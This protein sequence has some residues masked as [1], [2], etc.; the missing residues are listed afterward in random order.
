[1]Y[2]RE[3][4]K[5]IEMLGGGK[6]NT[7]VYSVEHLPTG[8]IYALK[9]VEAKDLDKLNEYKEEAFQLSKVQHHP[10]ILKCHG[11]YFYQTKHKSYKLGIISEYIS[12]E[13]NL[14]NLFRKKEKS[15]Q[16]WSEEELLKIAYS[17]IDTLAYLESCGICHRDIKPQ[18][19][20][21]LSNFEIKIIDFGESIEHFEED[22][23][24]DEKA[25]IRGTP[26]Y[27]SPILW[28]GHVI[29]KEREI[30]HNMFKSDVFSTGLVLFQLASFKDISGFNM[31][32]DKV[33]GEKLIKEGIKYI[34][35]KYSN[36]L[37]D[38]I[39]KML[40]FNENERPTFIEMGKFI[41]SDEYVPKAEKNIFTQ[42]EELQ[43]KK[44]SILENTD[45][46]TNIS[47]SKE[48]SNEERTKKFIEYIQNNKVDINLNKNTYWFEYGGNLCEKMNFNDTNPQSKLTWKFLFKNKFDF[49]YH[50]NIV[51]VNEKY[52]YFLIGGRD[53]LNNFQFKDGE[54]IQKAPMN[55]KRS[56]TITAV[57]N[58]YIF[59]IGGF[60]FIQK[61]QMSSIEVYEIEKDSWRKNYIKN[62]NVPRSSGNALVYNGDAILVFGGFNK[63][64]GTLNSIEKIN[65]KTKDCE[66]LNI[67]MPV[68]LRRFSLLKISDSKILILGG[69]EKH[70]KNNEDGFILNIQSGKYDIIKDICKGGILEHEIIFD[71]L[72]YM[73]LFFEN[74]FGTSPPEHQQIDFINTITI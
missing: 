7:K 69:V 27:L 56:F 52:G 20:F 36:H 62:L 18:N 23:E 38:I 58:H 59:A 3:D 68:A 2:R 72:G 25:T 53:E 47:E 66:L 43:N 44:K 61:D 12:R 41:A 28:K 54:V 49:N 32:T 26:M 34:S 64:N 67:I 16:H 63:L 14:E 70:S 1:M 5:K 55:Y 42:I 29:L 22:E 21:L 37:V 40:I 17:L 6:T 10:N 71:E 73:H 30:F 45:S 65:L 4:F 57:I 19:L 39:K 50:F 8:K 51:Y 9:E 31:K 74:N 24:N 46:R 60:D 13:C 33:D 48:S 15:R 35:K 11:Y